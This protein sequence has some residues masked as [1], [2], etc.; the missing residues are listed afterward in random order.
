M[1]KL[2]SQLSE[3]G[4][5]EKRVRVESG[6]ANEKI[7]KMKRDYELKL[8]EAKKRI[9]ALELKLRRISALL[10]AESD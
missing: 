10:G 5:G 9:D 1:T 4:K 3:K 8:K 7:G 2:E 6:E